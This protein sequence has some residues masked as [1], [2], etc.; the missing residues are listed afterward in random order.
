[1]IADRVAGDCSDDKLKELMQSVEPVTKKVA[2]HI[3]L[4]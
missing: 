1:M 3:S 2:S 4:R